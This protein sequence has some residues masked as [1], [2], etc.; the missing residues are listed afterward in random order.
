VQRWFDTACFADPAQYQFGNYKIGDARGPHVFN[1]DLSASKRTAI[2]KRA[3]ELRIEA[4][5]VFNHAQ[6]AN[7]NTTFG[8]AAFGSITG[9]RL[10]PREVQ[11]GVRFLF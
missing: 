2:G 4:F 3:L 5:N 1:T 10:T 11:L 7:P 8:N 6:F 9:T